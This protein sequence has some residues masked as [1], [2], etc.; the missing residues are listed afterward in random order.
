MALSATT[1]RN[2]MFYLVERSCSLHLVSMSARSLLQNLGYRDRDSSQMS[3][4]RIPDF[5]RRSYDS[6]DKEVK[7]TPGIWKQ[8][9]FQLLLPKAEYQGLIMLPSTTPLMTDVRELL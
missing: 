9:R 3:V 6:R 2:A 4:P 7:R 8:S 1:I 5:P